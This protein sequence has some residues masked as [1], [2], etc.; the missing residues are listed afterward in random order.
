MSQGSEAAEQFTHEAIKITESAAKL[1]ALG[2]KN[3]AL[4][5]IALVNENPK[6]AG[7]T[8]MAKLLKS[9]KELKVFDVKETDMATFAALCKQ[10]GI[11]FSGIKN[12]LDENGFIDVLTRAEDVSKIN[13]VL[14]K[15]NYGTQKG[16][17][18]KVPKKAD[19][20]ALQ[21]SRLNEQERGLTE[22]ISRN[23]EKKSIR[24][25]IEKIE[26]NQDKAIPVEP[27]FHPKER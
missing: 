21:N 16:M 24:A 15:M 27:V 17:E 11:L 25:T 7:K 23:P 8:K 20:H 19:S 26:L 9:G 4:L 2:A 22:K 12:S 1:T 18:D 5:C 10:Y 6:L 13:R 14:E 3:L